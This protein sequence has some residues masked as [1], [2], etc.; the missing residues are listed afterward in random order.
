MARRKNAVFLGTDR[1]L[2]FGYHDHKQSGGPHDLVDA[3]YAE[4]NAH[5]PGKIAVPIPPAAQVVCTHSLEQ[6][7]FIMADHLTRQI[8][9]SLGYVAAA[10]DLRKLS[11]IVDKA[12]AK[13]AGFAIMTAIDH[14][15]DE[16][17]SHTYDTS[18]LEYQSPQTH[19][20]VVSSNVNVL[21]D[22]LQAV[23]SAAAGA[24][25]GTADHTADAV[26]ALS[27]QL[28]FSGQNVWTSV[29]KMLAAL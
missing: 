8:A 14:M 29:N 5:L 17:R 15:Q 7:A 12:T 13:R 16:V 6:Q 28:R 24:W 3:F 9:P 23:E 22:V 11:P 2:G 26:C 1:D 4:I 20:D 18:P 10:L 27:K 21:H 25:E 19:L